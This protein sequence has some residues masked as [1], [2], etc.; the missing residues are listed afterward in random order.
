MKK[1]I[2]IATVLLFALS[3]TACSD[4]KLEKEKQEREHAAKISKAVKMPM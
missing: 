4:N 1:F 2:A 3:L